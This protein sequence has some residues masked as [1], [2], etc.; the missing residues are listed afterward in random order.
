MSKT[1]GGELKPCPFC[2]VQLLRD[3]RTA[4]HEINECPLESLVIET[5][6]FP[7]WNRRSTPD[8]AVAELV[9]GL[10]LAKSHLDEML[11]D[12]KW[13][14]IGHCPVLDRANALIAKHT[15]PLKE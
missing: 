7:A 10:N 14:P 6:Q 5:Y 11:H 8:A 12:E 1:E 4:Y 15:P 2:G 3:E 9:E 13:H